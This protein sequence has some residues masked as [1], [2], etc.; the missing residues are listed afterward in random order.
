[1]KNETDMT[2]IHNPI[3][4]RINC[5]KYTALDRPAP[6]VARAGAKLVILPQL[7]KPII[8]DAGIK[9]RNADYKNASI[10]YEV[11][12]GR[13]SF[14]FDASVPSS[15]DAYVFQVNAEVTYS[16]ADP[17]AVVQAGVRD[18]RAEVRKII[19]NAIKYYSQHRAMNQI[20]NLQSC[21]RNQVD[22]DK[23]DIARAL[24]RHGYQFFDLTISIRR[25]PQD[26][27]LT[28]LLGHIEA[29]K[30]IETAKEK[31]RN[32]KRI[33][34]A[35]EATH[36]KQYLKSDIY[37][38]LALFTVLNSQALDTAL[39]R[40]KDE[41]NAVIKHYL[42]LMSGL[43]SGLED[44]VKQKELIRLKEQLERRFDTSKILITEEVNGKL[45][46]SSMNA[47]TQNGIEKEVNK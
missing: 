1:M 19:L 30:A 31:L 23:G 2:D 28:T 7:G 45:P 9:M 33:S 35:N 4:Q 21:I 12:V 37:S 46:N 24:N 18:T 22:G 39:Q 25:D 13:D 32:T 15:S 14:S 38:R 10:I 43:T 3:L 27:Y 8:I 44:H 34:E 20:T 26:I 5:T 42:D 17:I 29:Q 41:E 16:I 6:P 36:I 47:G 11:N 40:I